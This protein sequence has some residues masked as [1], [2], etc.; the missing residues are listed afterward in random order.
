MTEDEAKRLAV[1]FG[2]V[3]RGC[4]YRVEAACELANAS[5][6]GWVWTMDQGDEA[7]LTEVG[8]EQIFVVPLTVR[9]ARLAGGQ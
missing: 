8:E 4:P 5:G 2:S 6:F 7:E 3:D 1:I 9:P